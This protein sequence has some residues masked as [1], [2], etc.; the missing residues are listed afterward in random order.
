LGKSLFFM[1]EFGGNDYVFLLSASKTVDETKAYVPTVVNAITIGVEVLRSFLT[2]IFRRL[3]G[4][5]LLAFSG[6]PF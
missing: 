3:A 2:T 6:P 4:R 5:L 1:G